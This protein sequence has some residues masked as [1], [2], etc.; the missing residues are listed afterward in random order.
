MAN[1]D[2]NHGSSSGNKIKEDLEA[3]RAHWK[4]GE[5]APLEVASRVIR[6]LPGG[7][8]WEVASELAEMKTGEGKP[9]KETAAEQKE[10][11]LTYF[12]KMELI[13]LAQSLEA[14]TLAYVSMKQNEASKERA[15][16]KYE[17]DVL[18]A[19]LPYLPNFS[20]RSVMEETIE[21][22]K[23]VTTHTKKPA[24]A[25]FVSG[26]RAEARIQKL[27]S[28][29][30]P[31]P[32]SATWIS[33]Y[34]LSSANQL[35]DPKKK[36]KAYAKI[37][38][39]A[40]KFSERHGG[41]IKPEISRALWNALCT[42]VREDEDNYRFALDISQELDNLAKSEKEVPYAV[43]KLKTKFDE[44]TGHNAGSLM[45]GTVSQ[46]LEKGKPVARE[47][48]IQ[49]LTFYK[50]STPSVTLNAA[51]LLNQLEVPEEVAAHKREVICRLLMP[52]AKE[53][54]T[55]T[56]GKVATLCV[57]KTQERMDEL[58]Q[59]IMAKTNLKEEVLNYSIVRLGQ[60]EADNT[61]STRLLSQYSVDE[62]VDAVVGLQTPQPNDETLVLVQRTTDYLTQHRRPKA[63]QL[64]RLS[65][66]FGEDYSQVF[67]VERGE[68]PA[69]SSGIFRRGAAE[70]APSPEPGEKAADADVP[71]P[72]PPTPEA[73]DPAEEAEL[74]FFGGSLSSPHLSAPINLSSVVLDPDA[75]TS[76]ST[77]NELWNFLENEETL[78]SEDGNQ[79]I[80]PDSSQLSGADLGKYAEA[81][82][83]TDFAQILEAFG[84][85]KAVKEAHFE[86]TGQPVYVLMDAA[87]SLAK[88][89]IDP[90]NTELRDARAKL[91]A[92]ILFHANEPVNAELLNS[93]GPAELANH[94]LDHPR[95]MEPGVMHFIEHP[96]NEAKSLAFACPEILGNTQMSETEKMR[97][98]N[99]LL[100]W[101]GKSA[102]ASLSATAVTLTH[103]TSK[104]DYPT[105]LIRYISIGVFEEFKKIDSYVH[106]QNIIAEIDDHG[107]DPEFVETMKAQI[108]QEMAKK[109][110]AETE[111]AQPEDAEDVGLPNLDDAELDIEPEDD[112][113]REEPED[114]PSPLAEAD[115]EAIPDQFKEELIPLL[116]AMRGE[117][118]EEV[119]RAYSELGSLL[120]PEANPF[121]DEKV[122][123]KLYALATNE[124]DPELARKATGALFG[125]VYAHPEMATSITN[126]LTRALSQVPYKIGTAAMVEAIMEGSPEETDLALTLF[127]ERGI[128]QNYNLI[129]RPVH[130]VAAMEIVDALNTELATQVIFELT[131]SVDVEYLLPALEPIYEASPQKTQEH[132]LQVLLGFRTY[133][134]GSLFGTPE[135]EQFS[136]EEAELAEAFLAKLGGDSDPEFSMAKAL[137]DMV[138]QGA[139]EFALQKLADAQEEDY[140]AQWAETLAHS[141]EP[142]VDELIMEKLPELGH[143]AQLLGV[144]ALSA[145]KPTLTKAQLFLEL[146][147]YADDVGTLAAG[148]LAEMD[149]SEFSENEEFD[150]LYAMR[151]HHRENLAE[152]AGGRLE[153]FLSE[154]P[155]ILAKEQATLLGNLARSDERPEVAG[156]AQK[157]LL[158]ESAQTL[159]SLE[160]GGRLSWAKT[161]GED[162]D[163]AVMSMYAIANLMTRF[164]DPGAKFIPSLEE[165]LTEYDS[166]HELVPHLR[167]MEAAKIS[168]NPRYASLILVPSLASRPE[169]SDRAFEHLEAFGKNGIKAAAEAIQGE[170]L[171]VPTSPEAQKRI[172]QK[173]LELLCKK[174]EYSELVPLLGHHN[175]LVRVSVSQFLEGSP[176]TPEKIEALIEGIEGGD[177]KVV[178]SS[179]S[180]LPK[181]RK[182]LPLIREAVESE[183]PRV[184]K[185]AARVA[186]GILSIEDLAAELANSHVP[187]QQKQAIADAALALNP[188]VVGDLAAHLEGG[189]LLPQVLQYFQIPDSLSHLDFFASTQ[190]NE[191]ENLDLALS[192]FAQELSKVHDVPDL[193]SAHQ[194][195]VL[196]LGILQAFGSREA[197]EV[198]EKVANSNSELLLAGAK[199]SEDPELIYKA[200]QLFW[201]VGNMD[202]AVEAAL[203]FRSMDKGGLTHLEGAADQIVFG[204]DEGQM[205]S[206]ASPLR[207][208]EAEVE[209][210]RFVKEVAFA[211]FVQSQGLNNS[212][213]ASFGSTF[214]DDLLSI[215]D[216]KYGLEA[217]SALIWS[218]QDHPHKAHIA[219]SFNTS[220]D[221][222]LQAQADV[223]S[224]IL[225]LGDYSLLEE[226]AGDPQIR[227]ILVIHAERRAMEAMASVDERAVARKLRLL[228]EMV[229]RGILNEGH[230]D[231]LADHTSP[232]AKR[233]MGQN[234]IWDPKFAKK[235]LEQERGKIRAAP[236]FG[237]NVSREAAQADARN[238]AR[239]RP[240]APRP[241]GAK[242]TKVPRGG[243]GSSN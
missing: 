157:I 49:L 55:N 231:T 149:F 186:A 129:A 112:L 199:S 24:H 226:A 75:D 96:D 200:S 6:S 70:P 190:P 148:Q 212:L 47:R 8:E 166:N 216:P 27:L 198:A 68:L 95:A 197:A 171:P 114:A 19:Y 5:P 184:R 206:L 155:S 43:A 187:S 131:G 214:G 193:Q 239:T 229:E 62:L 4:R 161:L 130:A 92:E 225:L 170:N 147:G 128:L 195:M 71:E 180:L 146:S 17:S 227:E 72:E 56:K 50:N 134:E 183:H 238:L 64:A 25:G 58:L 82:P 162:Q 242:Q 3:V 18:A 107:L 174:G 45:L 28:R 14:A 163:T 90:V 42:T 86:Y 154:N 105:Q 204:L 10:Q 44:K 207:D 93:D 241:E 89:E 140:A 240:K 210:Y 185:V 1:S 40:Q 222:S 97:M 234:A 205:E 178:L 228:A 182:H 137:E 122:I 219:N 60:S 150:L 144:A 151:H 118:Q 106:I 32:H 38:F 100:S 67:S 41:V 84:E 15:Q 232:T 111:E 13:D 153:L 65:D 29:P 88:I 87:L 119:A 235:A 158:S 152:A 194:K 59:E 125:T 138:G 113:L 196:L 181:D 175:N 167:L 202:L 61:I 220:V 213:F 83:I 103:T 51:L 177:E 139:A 11:I 66:A 9:G 26:W 173:C 76:D 37:L 156:A 221:D 99:N 69:G 91:V 236:V 115:P 52:I 12:A 98:A 85:G 39:V 211:E 53:E 143:T 80:G 179:L 132:I 116:E 189:A 142:R 233:I 46:L 191:K 133:D 104:E 36:A 78:R 217:V 218:A 237:G 230:I 81:E 124:E 135:S 136:L 176:N 172:A 224:H 164:W 117:Y 94:W 208:P 159:A 110:E 201:S 120:V 48:Q 54:V 35:E 33:N 223:L 101:Y 73:V 34:L 30:Q 22:A 243:S 192:Y 126:Q 2:K 23:L 127:A 7:G 168:K 63:N 21:L 169:V 31:T 79:E 77:Q 145:R 74:G 57:P 160:L 203:F 108:E 20:S 209:G 121:Q 188:D 123:E 141:K 102:A 165:A 109:T 215:Y 16:I